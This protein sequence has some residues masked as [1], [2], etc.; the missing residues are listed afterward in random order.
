M[1]PGSAE[2]RDRERPAVE[3]AARDRAG[4]YLGDA[5]ER[6]H[7]Q[8][9]ARRTGADQLADRLVYEGGLAWSARWLLPVEEVPHRTVAALRGPIVALWTVREVVGA[10]AGSGEYGVWST[11]GGPLVR[12]RGTGPVVGATTAAGR[13]VL[14]GAEGALLCLWE[15]AGGAPVE[16]D[17]VTL[18]IPLRSLAA[19][20]PPDGVPVLVGVEVTVPS[21]DW[22]MLDTA[23]TG[24]AVRGWAV[25]GDPPRL[26]PHPSP[27]PADPVPVD[28]LYPK[29]SVAVRGRECLLTG[30]RDGIVRAWPLDA[31]EGEP[32]VPLASPAAVACAARSDGR[33]VAVTAHHNGRIGA[34]DLAEGA[35]PE[36]VLHDSHDAAA[37]AC[38]RAPGGP[39]LA[40][41]GGLDGRVCV[42]DV[43]SGALLR[44]IVVPPGGELAGAGRY[45]PTG[46]PDEP[47]GPEPVRD[48]TAAVLPD[49]R[50][51]AV[52]VGNLGWLRWW[53]LSSGEALGA[54]RLSHWGRA[55]T[56]DR[57][58]VVATTGD[59]LRVYDLASA[60]AVAVFPR[61]GPDP[62][63]TL[64]VAGDLVVAL[65]DAGRLHRYRLAH[66]APVGE[67]LPGHH[68]DARTVACG[69]HPDGRAIA[70]SGGWDGTVRVWDLAAG[71][72]LHRIPVEHPVYAVALAGDGSIVVGAHGVMGVLRLHA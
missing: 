40:V 62:L 44:T 10:V 68:R 18:P 34:W 52:S 11:G 29:V 56:G 33:W 28:P 15:A 60:R 25:A 1:A 55:V 26:R 57:R 31:G 45:R 69:R 13:H 42:F 6:A 19:V 64:D 9:A 4:A 27:P 22:S 59:D 63:S 70:V 36:S 35:P 65:D 21:G 43:D 49:G 16:L 50:P 3:L 61:A 32:P 66:G 39:P 46:V 47:P 17:R 2:P 30:G 54:A 41:T 7:L 14:A 38:V 12:G 71:R 24:G 72:E 51:V 5:D 23:T 58:V 53:C 20:Q 48:V 8:L 37:V 67:P